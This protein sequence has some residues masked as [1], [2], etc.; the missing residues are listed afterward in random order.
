MMDLKERYFR[1]LAAA[2]SNDEHP[3]GNYTKLLRY[4]YSRSFYYV[5]PMDGNRSEDGID[6]RYRGFAYQ[7]GIDYREIACVLDIQD[8]SVLEM[9]VSLAT[10]ME[11]IAG[12]YDYGDRTSIWFWKMVESIGLLGM[13]DAYIELDPIKAQ[14]A[15]EVIVDIF[16]KR[17]YYPN[18]QG[19]LFTLPDSDC[20]LRQMEI[21][22]QMCRFLAREA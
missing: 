7:C 14:A 21:W 1:W 13:T 5:I 16:L 18:G 10:R 15:I 11:D 6:L 9:M 12:D 2:V 4:L 8:C 3:A 22:N 17:E 20:D 19:G